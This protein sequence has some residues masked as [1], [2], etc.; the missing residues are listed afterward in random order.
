MPTPACRCPWYWVWYDGPLCCMLVVLGVV[1]KPVVLRARSGQPDWVLGVVQMKARCAGRGAVLRVVPTARPSCR[2]GT[3][4]V[5]S[6]HAGGNPNVSDRSAEHAHAVDAAAR[7][8]DRGFFDS[9]HQP[10]RF[11]DLSVAVQLMGNPFGR[12]PSN[13]ELI[14]K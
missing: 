1:R 10:E 3:V 11:L 12:W 2:R 13:T 6:V 9:Q 8:Q 14:W 5:W 4:P 7:P